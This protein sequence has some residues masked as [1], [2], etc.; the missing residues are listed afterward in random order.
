V[1][2]RQVLA[3]GAP[4]TFVHC[5]KADPVPPIQ[6]SSATA[7]HRVTLLTSM[8]VMFPP[9]RRLLDEGAV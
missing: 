3:L 1:S 9:Q 7:A 2:S 8:I 5:A 4:F 6:N